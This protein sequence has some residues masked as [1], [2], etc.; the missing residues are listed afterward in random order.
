VWPFAARVW[1]LS[2][3]FVIAAGSQLAMTSAM[4]VYQ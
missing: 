3:R 1:A 2:V 4:E